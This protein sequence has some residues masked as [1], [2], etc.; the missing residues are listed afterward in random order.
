MKLLYNGQT[1]CDQPIF[2]RLLMV[3]EE[4]H[5]MDRPSVTFRNWGSAKGTGPLARSGQRHVTLSKE[6]NS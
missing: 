6:S 1:F 2:K 5:F 4:L 3:A